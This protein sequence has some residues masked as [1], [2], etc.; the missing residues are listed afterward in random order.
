MQR[1]GSGVNEPLFS[2]FTLLRVSTDVTLSPQ[3][4]RMLSKQLQLKLHHGIEI[5]LDKCVSR[6]SVVRVHI[7]VCLPAGC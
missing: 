2:L 1:T 3:R 6:S 5:K 7:G 4:R